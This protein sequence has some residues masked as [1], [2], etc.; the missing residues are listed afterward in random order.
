MIPLRIQMVAG[1]IEVTE[2]TQPAHAS[3][4]LTEVAA[5]LP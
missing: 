4:W 2:I 5:P 1:S 3:L